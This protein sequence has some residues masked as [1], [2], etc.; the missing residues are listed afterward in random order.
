MTQANRAS[1]QKLRLTRFKCFTDDS[2]EL[3]PLTLLTGLNGTGKSTFLQGLLLAIE[4]LNSR[5][6]TVSLNNAGFALGTAEDVLTF[7]ADQSTIEIGLTQLEPDEAVYSFSRLDNDELRLRVGWIGPAPLS[8]AAVAYLC[9]ERLG[10]RT[11]YPLAS[12]GEG[13]LTVGIQGEYTAQFLQA[14]ENDK[15]AQD[16]QHPSTTDDDDADVLITLRKQAEFW[17]RE[18]VPGLSVRA[19]NVPD[20]LQSALLFSK[21]PAPSDF[22]RPGNMGFGVSYALPIIV[23]GL[24]MPAGG[25][26]VVENPEAHLHPAGQS[27]IGRFLGLLAAVGVQVIVET[28]SD[29][30]LNGI[31]LAAMEDNHPLRR[32]DVLIHAFLAT[33]QEGKR[34]LEIEIDKHGGFS[35]NPPGFFDQS[36]KD[37]Q[38]ILDARRPQA[39]LAKKLRARAEEQR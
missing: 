3:R 22:V 28:H 7:G 4:A 24:A 37:L 20:A 32:Q 2:F 29:H 13:V 36:S 25:L 34:V 35:Q 5:D 26:F 33:P 39:Q 23:Q 9:A 14:H 12:Q 18:L 21:E 8:F 31:C 38:A 10:P 17:M 11:S 15:V 30:V 16:R 6:G 27:A 19:A 1:L